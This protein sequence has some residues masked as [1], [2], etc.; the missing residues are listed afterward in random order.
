MSRD[1]SALLAP[2]AGR[3]LESPFGYRRFKSREVR[4][5]DVR[6]GGDNPIVLQSMTISDTLNTEAV[7]AEAI[8]LWEAG[9]QLVRITAPGPKD[10]E[11][12]KNI[13]AE[14]K[15]RGFHFPVVADIHFAPKAALIAAEYVE[16]VRINPGNFVDRKRFAVREYTESE[17]A[18]E[19]ERVREI[20]I[21]LV[22]RCRELG[23]AMRI[24]AN[25][26]SLSDRIM[27]RFGDTPLGMVESAL[28]FTKIA[29]EFDYHDIVVSM[30]ASNPQV[31]VQAYRLLVERFYVEG[32]A[33]PL[34]LGVTE[35]GNGQD[36]RIKSAIG[37][38]S[39]LDDGLGDTI[40]V[41]L[42]E[43]A[44]HELP[45]A[46]RIAE[47][48][49]QLHARGSAGSAPARDRIQPA[50]EARLES[51]YQRAVNPYIFERFLS[52]AAQGG[53]F[54]IGS[55]H[56]HR[57]LV[58][59]ANAGLQSM[60]AT[61]A[62]TR[63]L[64][65]DGADAFIIPAGALAGDAGEQWRAW[66]ADGPPLILDIGPLAAAADV[67]RAFLDRFAGVALELS[68]VDDA[69][70]AAD[71]AAL[72][73]RLSALFETSR[74][75]LLNLRIGDLSAATS[76]RAR[77]LFQETAA[78]SGANLVFSVAVDSATDADFY[79][80]PTK[81]VRW[82]AALFLDL[83]AEGKREL[84]PLLLRGRYA[85]LEDA[86]FDAS[87]ELGP[88]FLDGLGDGLWIETA[89][90]TSGDAILKLELDLL[91]AVR[92]RLS[93]TEFIS[94]PSCGRTLFDLQSTT[95]RIQARTGHLKGVK[96]AIM[97][98]IVNGPGEMADADFGY[99]G[100]GPGKIHLYRGKEIVKSN[101]PSEAADAEL[102]E[103][104]R[105]HGM[106]KEPDER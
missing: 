58:S 105:A 47:R 8:Q 79:V 50:S 83:A 12:L 57:A 21:P 7:V 24:G 3:Y 55:K 5:G 63:A 25:H 66:P 84:P 71:L 73:G 33:Y 35:A 42:T 11:N 49:N 75:V 60:A 43:D 82:I 93:K 87:L 99:V 28:E 94:C 104:I 22:K 78:L 39:L 15:R 85:S 34:H 29:A 32:M 62:E 48:Y 18:E 76:E 89:S 31:M 36:G 70:L 30:K 4:V 100:A 40:R 102:I 41:S 27:N 96:I 81:A 9:S 19:L 2:P 20:F 106:W 23:R 14:L 86:V 88:L 90:A 1:S 52:E 98:C 46:R 51:R 80:S 67:Q 53:S 72:R 69:R 65:A 77:R 26:G 54:Y 64:A 101:I 92:L 74:M 56:Q 38:G 45:A 44:I 95:A 17:Y 6:I 10:A 61:L 91:Q 97:G 16:K 37:I 13:K 103:L 59:L 68:L